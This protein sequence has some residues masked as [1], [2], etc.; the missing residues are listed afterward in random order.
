MGRSVATLPSVL[1]VLVCAA[2]AGREPRAPSPDAA[3]DAGDA[4]AVSPSDVASSAD[5]ADDARAPDAAPPDAWTTF[6]ASV[7]GRPL[8]RLDVGH[9]PRR[10]LWIGGIHG[11]EPEGSV[12]TAELPRAL[13]AAG[14]LERVTLTLVEDL[15]P[16]GR[17]RGT[18]GNAH[19][20]DLNR[21]FPARNASRRTREP[22]SQPE[23]RALAELVDALRPELVFVAHSWGGDPRDVREFVNPDGPAH[24]LAE[25]FAAQAPAY[26]LVESS[27]ISPTPGSLGSWLGV[28]LGLPVLTIEYPRGADP[29]R[30]W[31]DTRAAILAC[32][33]AF[34]SGT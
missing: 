26:E 15:D 17:A 4:H 27:E 7:E 22:L 18:R 5:D 24:D 12:A 10:V 20:V 2:C 3:V 1:V 30:C 31:D 28:D 19:G 23:S 16:D 9:G 14:L 29:S 32:L 11:N 25:L 33:A 13:A 8:R 34:A 21:D 6:G